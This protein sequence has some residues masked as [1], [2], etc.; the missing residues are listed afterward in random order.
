MVKSLDKIIKNYNNKWKIKQAHIIHGLSAVVS[1]IHQ[2]ILHLF[3]R[4]FVLWYIRVFL[5][6]LLLELFESTCAW[7]WSIWSTAI[8]STNATSNLELSID[9]DSL[10]TILR[11]G[12]L[13]N[14][15]YLTDVDVNNDGQCVIN[16]GT[17]FRC[18]VL[19]LGK[20]FI[21][22]INGT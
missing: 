10:T 2:V 19:S 9:S 3:Y 6:L 17:L 5:L 14:Y 18:T 22:L 15:Y 13:I 16:A 7:S 20:W 12:I 4:F 1:L 21:H 8:L 11:V